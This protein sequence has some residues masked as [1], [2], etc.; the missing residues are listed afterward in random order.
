M[1]DAESWDRLRAAVSAAAGQAVELLGRPEVGHR[2][3]EPSALPE[4]TVGGLATHLTQ[5]LAAAVGWLAAEP[6]PLTEA[7]LGEVYGLARVNADEGLDGDVARRIRGW[8]ESGRT[9]GPGPML[10]QVRTDLAELRALLPTVAADRLVPSVNRPGTG[11]RADDYLRTRCVEF[12][13]H[14]DDLAISCDLPTPEPDPAAADAAISALVETCRD[15]AGD[16]SVL[17]ALTRPGR[18]DDETLRAL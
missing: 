16:L 1:T 3:T 4:M 11:M 17:R 8:A 13:V 14:V 7:T 18:A 5:M 10:A 9:A 12:L 6:E 2:W 15:R